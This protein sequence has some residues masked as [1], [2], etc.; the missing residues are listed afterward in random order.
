MKLAEYLAKHGISQQKFARRVGLS[1]GTVSLL[2]R[3]MTWVS[4]DA[5]QKIAKATR[6]RVTANDFVQREAAE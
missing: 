6:G 1:K 5:A 4:R 3:G 2:A